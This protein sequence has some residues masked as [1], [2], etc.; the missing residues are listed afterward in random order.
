M[1]AYILITVLVFWTVVAFTMGGMLVN[2]AVDAYG[3]ADPVY[4]NLALHLLWLTIACMIA[5][6]RIVFNAL[7]HYF[8]ITLRR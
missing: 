5:L 4:G 1:G 8:T 3:N 6:P 2:D 7:F